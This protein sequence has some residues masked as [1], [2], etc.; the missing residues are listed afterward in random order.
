MTPPQPVGLRPP[1][2]EGNLPAAPLPNG[3]ARLAP[4]GLGAVG[5]RLPQL[6]EHIEMH[7]GK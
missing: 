2:C 6:V 1:S 5:P 7:I 3:V 4:V